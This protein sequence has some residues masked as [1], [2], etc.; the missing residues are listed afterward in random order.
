MDTLF[1]KKVI[2]MKEEERKR[3]FSKDPNRSG[4]SFRS[5]QSSVS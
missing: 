1:K 2:D 4:A 3:S 5:K